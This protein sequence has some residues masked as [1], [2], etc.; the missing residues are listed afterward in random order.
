MQS[1]LKSS[2]ILFYRLWW[3]SKLPN[4]IVLPRL[5]G[6]RWES[7][8]IEGNWP[9]NFHWQMK[10]VF[11][12]RNNVVSAVRKAPINVKGI[13]PFWPSQSIDFGRFDPWYV[14]YCS[15]SVFPSG[16]SQLWP[17]WTIF[18]ILYQ[19]STLSHSFCSPYKQYKVTNV[20]CNH[21]I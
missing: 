18:T 5:P 9:P 13:I 14:W 8:R 20:Q 17:E 11:Q 21:P 16:T 19:F 2:W 3:A 12:C 6:K 7:K 15:I 4:W 10:M 1:L